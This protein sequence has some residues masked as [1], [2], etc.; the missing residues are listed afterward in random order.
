MI[1]GTD[2]KVE[3]VECAGSHSPWLSAPD[4]VLEIVRRAAGEKVSYFGYNPVMLT[5]KDPTEM[6]KFLKPP[7]GPAAPATP[8]FYDANWPGWGGRRTPS[9]LY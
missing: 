8:D 1:E 2:G 5:V 4:L 9:S 6:F 3:V 7:V